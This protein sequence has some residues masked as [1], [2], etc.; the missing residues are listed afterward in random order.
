MTQSTRSRVPFILCVAATLL[1]ACGLYGVERPPRP[2]VGQAVL[3][4]TAVPEDV[5]CLRVTV[6]GAGRTEERE[7]DVTAAGDMAE[8]LS[9]LPLGMV[10][11]KGEA[12]AGACTAV[13]KT[14]IAGWASEPVNA[15][16]VLGRL[17]TVTLVMTRNGRAK[18]DVSFQ[19][20]AACTAVGAACRL[21]SECCSRRCTVGLCAVA[22]PDAGRD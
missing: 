14:T 16:I 19:D 3:R 4:I 11:F 20:E 9:G 13:T 2:E 21:A 5:K 17:S 1:T 6:T 10:V 12:F 18:V 8:T 15:S 22:T 7:L